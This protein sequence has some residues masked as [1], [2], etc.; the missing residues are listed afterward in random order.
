[1]KQLYTFP[2]EQTIYAALRT[3]D[4]TGGDVERCQRSIAQYLANKTLV[5]HGANLAWEMSVTT[6]ARLPMSSP[7]LAWIMD[8]LFDDSM[9]A[10][11]TDAAFLSAVLEVRNGVRKQ[12]SGS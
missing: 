11:I 10:I 7:G 2:D 9:A 12:V 8:A 3:I 6:V 4:D 5:P 1:M